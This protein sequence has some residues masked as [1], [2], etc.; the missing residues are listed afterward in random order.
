MNNMCL[1]K[2]QL[3]SSAVS[4]TWLWD[5]HRELFPDQRLH[6]C[7]VGDCKYS[8]SRGYKGWPR[9]DALR[10]HEKVHVKA[11]MLSSSLKELFSSDLDESSSSSSS[12]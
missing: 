8:R 6:Y 11:E 12:D 9:R 7:E 10:R 2:A 1:Y 5:M 4:Q 3:I